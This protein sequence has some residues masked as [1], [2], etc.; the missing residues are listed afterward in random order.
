M[1]IPG[2]LKSEEDSTKFGKPMSA[3]VIV[4]ENVWQNLY[5]KVSLLGSVLLLLLLSGRR[6]IAFETADLIAQTA[7]PKAHAV[8]L[9]IS[10]G[11]V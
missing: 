8:D 4:A 9:E 5:R 7:S 11:F 6:V 3:I 2:E 10:A 1:N